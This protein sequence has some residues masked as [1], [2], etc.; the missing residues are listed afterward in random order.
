M[1]FDS[2]N[3]IN[4]RVRAEIWQVGKSGRVKVWRDIVW[5]GVFACKPVCHLRVRGF[6]ARMFTA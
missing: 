3:R 1:S 4:Y 6:Y 5:R 2:K